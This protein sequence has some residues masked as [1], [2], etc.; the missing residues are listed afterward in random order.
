MTPDELRRLT[1]TAADNPAFA[2]H[3]ADL[4]ID[5][6]HFEAVLALIPPTTSEIIEALAN[7]WTVKVWQAHKGRWVN[8]Y[9]ASTRW[10]SRLERHG[11]QPQPGYRIVRGEP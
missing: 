9:D 4:G 5:W 7:G 1:D 11:D 6:S 2:H 3:D 8:H 10:P